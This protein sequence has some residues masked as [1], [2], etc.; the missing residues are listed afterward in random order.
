MDLSESS[1]TPLEWPHSHIR[2]LHDKPPTE[3]S[4]GLVIGNG[5]YVMQKDS[6]IGRGS[7]SVVYAG[8][9]THPRRSNSN[10]TLGVEEDCASHASNSRGIDEDPTASGCL[11]SSG[12][13]QHFRRLREVAVKVIQAPDVERLWGLK[14]LNDEASRVAHASKQWSPRGREMAGWGVLTPVAPFGASGANP[15]GA[16]VSPVD[17]DRGRRV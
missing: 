11:S 10:A 9:A 12:E 14:A 1:T 5:R 13:S 3:S 2:R 16:C 7:F 8:I 15:P 4:R 6:V 17:S